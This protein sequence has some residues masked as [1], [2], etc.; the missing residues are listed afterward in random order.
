MG[1]YH[2]FSLQVR[3][4]GGSCNYHCRYCNY[5][6][7]KWDGRIMSDQTLSDLIE[8]FLNYSHPY[9]NFCWHGGEPTLAG[10]KFFSQ[11]LTLTEKFK[12]ADQI[13][14]HQLQTNGF[15]ITNEL[16]SIFNDGN[17]GIGV[18]I[19]GPE[20]VHNINRRTFG[21]RDTFRKTMEGLSLLR[22]YDIPVSVISTVSNTTL[23]YSREVFEYL[24]GAG[25][26]S[27]SYSPVFDSLESDGLSI[28]D[29]EWYNY[30][31]EVFE[32]WWEYGDP[33]IGIRE[34]DEVI[35]WISG[36]RINCCSSARTCC[37]WLSIDRD[38]SIY[39]CERYNQKISFGNISQINLYDIP[40]D[41]VFRKFAKQSRFV[42]PECKNCEY[43]R[44]CGNGCPN[45][46][47]SDNQLTAEGKYGFC[48]QRRS[49]YQLVS[50]TFAKAY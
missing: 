40:N 44:L 3:P 2:W 20:F 23:A 22:K 5:G 39:P 6:K 17:F 36:K 41:P 11:V 29:D 35:A 10:P 25:F 14:S 32:S 27:I 15:G 48:T 33:D 43:L 13:I 19:D 24:V 31:R 8:K 50:S 7:E 47:V 49:L 46:R 16:A 28:T 21:G 37:H 42:S 34:L 45:M 38:G 18:S 1:R 26:R 30:L 9:A 12:Q 4:V